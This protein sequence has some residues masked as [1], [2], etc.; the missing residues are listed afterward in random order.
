[1]LAFVDI[2]GMLSLSRLTPSFG[3]LAGCTQRKVTAKSGRGA[4]WE[5][6]G[7]VPKDGKVKALQ[8]LDMKVTKAVVVKEKDFLCRCEVVVGFSK[9]MDRGYKQGR[10][11]GEVKG[12]RES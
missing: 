3:Q 8:M 10:A 7:R 4:R 5:A 1:V 6:R 2:M 9:F 11:G 12:T